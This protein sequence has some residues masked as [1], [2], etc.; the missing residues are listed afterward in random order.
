MATKDR[1]QYLE[2]V[3]LF[4]DLPSETLTRIASLCHWRTYEPGVMI[5]SEGDP[6]GEVFFLA[7]GTVRA[8]IY[9]AG[10][11]NVIF[12]DME[13]G[14]LFGEIAAL[15]DGE[16]SASIEARTECLVAVLT[17]E[18]FTELLKSEPELAIRLLRRLVREIRRLSDRVVEFSTLS[19]RHRIHAELLRLSRQGEPSGNEGAIAPAPKLSDIADRIS[20]H[21]E[22]VSRELSR[23]IK[24]G[25]LIRTPDC[26]RITDLH[27]LERMVD[28]AQP[29]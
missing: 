2:T 19:V 25:L 3:D 13:E 23:L 4:A 15:D 29:D 5:F 10:G 12:Q 20:T 16:R 9:S 24:N 8:S 18:V 11:K 26:L 27:R 14:S 21:R 1:A 28:Q 6:A 7:T 17:A 22:A